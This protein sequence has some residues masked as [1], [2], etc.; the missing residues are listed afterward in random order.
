M[1]LRPDEAERLL[2]ITAIEREFWDTGCLVAGM[3][4]VGRGP[5][6]GPVVVACVCLPPQ[7]LIEGVRDSKQIKT[8]ARREAIYAQI[9]T[10]AGSVG[11]GIVDHRTIDSI[12][13]LQATRRA[14]ALAFRNM[15]VKPAHVLVDALA[16]LDIPATQHS[17]IR[18][19]QLS[20]L[21]GAAS[22]YAKV[23]RDRILTEMDDLY[24]GY[25]FAHN[26]G[27]GTPEHIE[28]IARVGPC[29]IHRM[30]FAPCSQRALF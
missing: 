9:A 26:K 11:V 29:A 5:L 1:T 24:P 8:E 14:C 4:E 7:P 17:Y 6:A 2:S 28:I 13:I 27:Y 20:Y 22:I 19:D 21:I 12:N 10:L 18:G 25:G 23:V 15:P 30:S 3:D 16:G